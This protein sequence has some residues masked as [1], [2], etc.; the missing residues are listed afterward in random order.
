MPSP[1]I[2]EIWGEREIERR[3]AW[4]RIETLLETVQQDEAGEEG[5]DKPMQRP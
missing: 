3:P 4:L 1:K 2:R 5:R